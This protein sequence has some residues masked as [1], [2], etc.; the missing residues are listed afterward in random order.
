MNSLVELIGRLAE[1][2]N[3][4]I[5]LRRMDSKLYAAAAEAMSYLPVAYDARMLDYQIAYLESSGEVVIDCSL[6]I[7]HDKKPAVLCPLVIVIARNGEMLGSGGAAV[8]AP[9]F[10]GGLSHKRKKAISQKFHKIVNAL[11][12]K[13]GIQSW[14][15]EEV[16]HNEIGLDGWHDELMLH[17][18]ELSVGHD[19]FVDLSLDMPAIKSRF[20]ESYK[21]LINQGERTWNVHLLADERGRDIWHEFEALHLAVAGKRTRSKC[22]WDI[23]WQTI[24]EGQAFLVYLLDSEEK[25]V[26]G[27]YFHTTA[28]E[29]VYAV[30]AYDRHLFDKPLGHVVQNRAISEMVRRGLRWYKIGARLYSSDV[31]HPTEKELSISHFKHGFSTH[32]MPVYR[33]MNHVA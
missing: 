6:V 32:M 25:M 26:G 14:L 22:T 3:L 2:Y 30:A 7:L 10:I 28:H 12:H 31:P 15:G 5:I 11:A 20:R 8:L 21:S 19:S 24:V 9:L 4:E 23:Q 17:G 29:G 18:A 1:E 13:I 27:G 16:F 33:T